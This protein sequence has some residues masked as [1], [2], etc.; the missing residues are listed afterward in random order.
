MKLG[1]FLGFGDK[2]LLEKLPP[3][4][5]SFTLP[6]PPHLVDEA[7]VPSKEDTAVMTRHAR[8]VFSDGELEKVEEVISALRRL[9]LEP[10]P[11]A[12]EQS[13]A[14]GSGRVI[15]RLAEAPETAPRHADP[16]PAAGTAPAAAPD[17]AAPPG[18]A[19]PPRGGAGAGAGPPLIQA[20]DWTE[21]LFDGQVVVAVRLLLFERCVWVWVGDTPTCTNISCHVQVGCDS[22]PNSTVLYGEGQDEAGEAFGRRLAKR[23]KG[24]RLVQVSWNV[25]SGQG[26]P[27]LHREVERA[28]VARL[29]LLGVAPGT[30]AAA[31]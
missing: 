11:L 25:G 28:V 12:A 17:Q 20:Q 14:A 22:I 13:A 3:G 19:A 10:D 6:Q 1:V 26:D 21:S 4:V 24:K 31:P 18:P 8:L 23:L 30:P 27:A 9:G 29:K 2:G 15:L 16:R 5:E 7:A